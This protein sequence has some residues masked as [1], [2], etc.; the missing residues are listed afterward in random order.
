MKHVR[1]AAEVLVHSLSNLLSIRHEHPRDL[2]EIA[3]SSCEGRVLFLE[4]SCLLDCEHFMEIGDCSGVRHCGVLRR[5]EKSKLTPADLCRA[6]SW[7]RFTEKK[8]NKLQADPHLL[9]SHKLK[10]C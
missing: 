5:R 1:V 10:L 4:E 9:S 3:N 2:V 6:V 8:V 7:A